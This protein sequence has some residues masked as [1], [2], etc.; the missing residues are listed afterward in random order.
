MYL[1]RI[2]LDE[3]KDRT[4]R[5]ITNPGVIHGV[6]ASSLPKNERYLWR[7]DSVGNRKYLLITS[8]TMPN[9]TFIAEQLGGSSVEMKNIDSFLESIQ[10]GDTRYFRIALNPVSEVNNKRV[11][12]NGSDPGKTPITWFEQRMANLGM[13]FNTNEVFVTDEK[14][15]DFV[16]GGDGKQGRI[17]FYSAVIEGRMSVVDKDKLCSA[18]VS[19]YGREKAFGSGMLTVA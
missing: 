18:I 14:W 10:T 7:I 17:S 4:T 3:K 13:K 12:W 15:V 11:A 8:A 6:V 2:E 1:S 19:G 9:L 5:A 16:H